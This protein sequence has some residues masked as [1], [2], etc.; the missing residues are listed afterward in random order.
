VLAFA[1]G[2]RTAK[3][4]DR[5]DG[6]S[7]DSCPVYEID[8][9][10]SKGGG[11]E[12]DPKMIRKPIRQ[13]TDTEIGDCYNCTLRKSMFFLF[14]LM[15]IFQC[16]SSRGPTYQDVLRLRSIFS[17]SSILGNLP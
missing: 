15:Q 17:C 10:L 6:Y 2:T 16:R 3:R 4:G 11:K 14:P 5:R 12:K 1:H 9:R 13:R 7:N 8:G